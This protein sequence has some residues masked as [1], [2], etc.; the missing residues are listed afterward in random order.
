M[1]AM[2]M[3]EMELVPENEDIDVYAQFEASTSL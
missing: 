2:A 1:D 3:L